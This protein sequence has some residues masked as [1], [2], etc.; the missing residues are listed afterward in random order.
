M[1][2]LT[3]GKFKENSVQSSQARERVSRNVSGVNSYETNQPVRAVLRRTKSRFFAPPFEAHG[4]LRRTERWL[5]RPG[6]SIVIPPLESSPSPVVIP[7]P[8]L[9]L[10]LPVVILNEVPTLSLEGKNL[11]SHLHGSTGMTPRGYGT[12]GQERAF[13]PLTPALSLKGRGRKVC[14]EC[15]KGRAEA[16]HLD[17]LG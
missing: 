8:V 6:P 13:L 7:L 3:T 10:T 4:T 15:Q 2:V 17:S 9:I 5:R 1:L 11:A 14:P 12:E 16:P